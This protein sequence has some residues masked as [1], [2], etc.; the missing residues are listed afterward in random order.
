M[1]ERCFRACQTRSMEQ[2]QDRDPS[3]GTLVGI[4]LPTLFAS[5]VTPAE[6]TDEALSK[7]SLEW[8]KMG[9]WADMAEMHG[10]LKGV[11]KGRFTELIGRI[12]SAGEQLGLAHTASRD[13]R[14]WLLE[15]DPQPK[16]GVGARA[17][18]EVTGYYS[19]SA[20]H[21]MANVSI[22]TLL[23][24]AD[25]AATVNNAYPK[26]KGFT[27]FANNRDAWQ[28]LN[29]NVITNLEAAAD[30]TGEDSVSSLIDTLRNLIEDPRWKAL[31]GRRD[32]D[33]HRWRPQSIEGGVNQGSPWET[34]PDGTMQMSVYA[35]ST[36]SVPDPRPLVQEAIDGLTALGDTMGRW[37]ELWP[38]ALRSLG[39]PLFKADT[40]D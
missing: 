27:P 26:A 29:S 13:A 12:A 38:E 17:L 30:A 4:V 16:H 8:Q 2:S 39:V 11:D 31:A 1:S 28:P 14:G 19:I 23:L 6:G 24:N 15:S 22:R 20:A 21:G 34:L 10:A 25:T 33:F 35:N 7:T 36:Y 3:L 37:L 32:I 5:T 9:R 18:A 40:D